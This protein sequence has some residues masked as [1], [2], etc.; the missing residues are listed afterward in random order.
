ML[1]LKNMGC[2]P[3]FSRSEILPRVLMVQK[4]G[5]CTIRQSYPSPGYLKHGRRDRSQ[6]TVPKKWMGASY[7]IVLRTVVGG[8][9][10]HACAG[11]AVDAALISARGPSWRILVEQVLQIGPVRSPRLK[12]RQDVRSPS[13]VSVCSNETSGRSLN[14]H[15]HMILG[16]ILSGE[17]ARR[18]DGRGPPKSA[19][20]LQQETPRL[21]RGYAPVLSSM[22]KMAWA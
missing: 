19:A 3:S 10:R 4:S 12:R 11:L 14:A 1:A 21:N 17:Q 5:R 22:R 8:D 18:S 9:L 6:L 15:S 2:T 13:K 16:M 20:L 7:C